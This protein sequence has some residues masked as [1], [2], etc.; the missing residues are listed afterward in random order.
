RGDER[1]DDQA[2]GPP[3]RGRAAGHRE[4]DRVPLLRPRLVH[5]GRRAER[6]RRHRALH[7][8][9]VGVGTG[10]SFTLTPEQRDLQEL[11]HEFA[12]NELRPVAAEWDAKDEFPPDLLA[13][14]ARLGLSSYRIPREYGGADVD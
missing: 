7:V 1:A 4:C 3:A 6:Q 5:H 14:A 2:D 8:L 11:A 12:A 13:K 9:S 10:I